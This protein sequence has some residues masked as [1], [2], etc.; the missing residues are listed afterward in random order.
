MEHEHPGNPV[1]PMDWERFFRMLPAK[2]LLM[3]IVVPPILLGAAIWW[4]LDPRKESFTAL[5]VGVFVIPIYLR[6]TMWRYNF[7]RNAESV[8][9]RI[10][11]VNRS[12]SLE[13]S[14]THVIHYCYTIGD[15]KYY[16][17]LMVVDPSGWNAGDKAYAL[18]FR[19]KP[20][21]SCLWVGGSPKDQSKSAFSKK[22][23]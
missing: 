10:T 21:N 15:T 7:Y 23:G 18:V 1:R 20:Q 4:W 19:K 13:F 16:D 22:Y 17:R 12:Q 5:W 6:M 2:L 8:E 14:G 9:C 3:F 11:R